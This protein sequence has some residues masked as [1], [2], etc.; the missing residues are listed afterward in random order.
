MKKI[1]FFDFVTSV[2]GVQTVLLNI[3]EKMS[4][5]GNYYT[6]SYL[7]PYNNQFTNK[8]KNA[9]VKKEKLPIWPQK[10]A[11]GWQNKRTRF[12]LLLAMGPF[13]LFYLLKLTM[14]M[15]KFD[16]IY[17]NQKKSLIITHLVNLLLRKKVVYHAHGFNK[18]SDIGLLFK[19]CINRSDIVIAVS[20]DVVNKLIESGVYAEKI[21]LVY[22]GV[23]IKAIDKIKVSV[24]KNYDYDMKNFNL[25]IACSI[26]VGKGLDILISAI[27]EL[28]KANYKINLY[29][30]GSVPKGGSLLYLTE[31][32]EYVN[33]NNLMNNVFFLGWQE[34]IIALMKSMD[35]VILPSIV[36]ESF[37]MVLAEAMAIGRPVIGSDIGGIK[38]V[39]DHEKNG[40]LTKP[41]DKNEI[42]KYLI[43]L[44]DKNKLYFEFCKNSRIKAEKSFSLDHQVLEIHRLIQS[45]F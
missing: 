42:K 8:I 9:F 24:P 36:E 44:L 1:L 43:K 11:L 35:A 37:G 10:T 6:I 41:G 40:Y 45:I 17:C 29:I 23:D 13:Y 2:G 30:A 25:F 33:K 21:H 39:I 3:L 20:K 19:H 14:F 27:N 31:L 16:L 22:N 7:D 34:N 32:E 18:S 15:K 26:H 12:I 5:M 28:F 4:N 38:E